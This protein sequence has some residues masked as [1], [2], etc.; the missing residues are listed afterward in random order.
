[1][2][3]IKKKKLFFTILILVTC[4]LS[5]NV[6]ASTMHHMDDSDCMVQTTCNGC[7]ISAVAYSSDSKF[8]YSNF[9][10]VSVASTSFQT[11]QIAPPLPP[12]KI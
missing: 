11:A 2:N 12:P 3:L 1:M 4:I 7:F 9:S 5:A 8:S 6:S 10:S